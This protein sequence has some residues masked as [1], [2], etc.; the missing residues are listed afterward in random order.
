MLD[1]GS[2]CSRSRQSKRKANVVEVDEPE[3]DK[4]TLNLKIYSPCPKM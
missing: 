1:E 3:E 4:K 2:L